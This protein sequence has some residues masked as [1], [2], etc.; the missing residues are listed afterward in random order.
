MC[1]GSTP[2]LFAHTRVPTMTLAQNPWLGAIGGI[3]LGEALATRNDIERAPFRYALL[4]DETWLVARALEHARLAPQALWVRR[5]DF[6]VATAPF[7]LYEVFLPAIG[8]SDASR[9]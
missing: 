7:A 9:A 3:T 1:C 6:R 2:W 5:S 4:T 8:R